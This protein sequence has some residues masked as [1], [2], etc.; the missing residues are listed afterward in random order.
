[1]FCHSLQV[2]TPMFGAALQNFVK[3]LVGYSLITYLLQVKDRHNANIMVAD[4]GS[5]FH[6]DFGFIF[7][8]SPGFNM[9]FENA[10]FKLTKEYVNLM[11][12]LDSITFKRF[13]D[14]LVN[15]FLALA[16]HQDEIIAVV[17]LFYMGMCI[18]L[19]PYIQVRCPSYFTVMTY[20][21]CSL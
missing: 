8:D 19:Q 12:G 1:M 10:P 18:P 17:D 9:N 21:I 5:I 7:G 14:L 13:E 2:Y 6:I 11:G 4:D 3:S 16:K 15:G 20:F